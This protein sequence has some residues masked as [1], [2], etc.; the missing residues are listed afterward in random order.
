M[1]SEGSLTSL[2]K[3]ATGPYP[4]QHNPISLLIPISLIFIL[5]F[6]PTYA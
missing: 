5:I 3:L 2:Q 4:H 6:S 1:E